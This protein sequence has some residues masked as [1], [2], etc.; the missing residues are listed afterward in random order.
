MKCTE[1][2]FYWKD[3]DEHYARCHFEQ[4]TCWDVPPCEYE[5]D[6]DN[7]YEGDYSEYPFM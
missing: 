1:C 7:E 4:R 3:D 2:C 5:D 6:T